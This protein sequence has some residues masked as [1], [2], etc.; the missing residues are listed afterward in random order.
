M[1][2]EKEETVENGEDRPAAEKNCRK[3]SRS[4][5]RCKQSANQQRASLAKILANILAVLRE[6]KPVNGRK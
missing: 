6:T 2:P 5:G 1:T 3:G 4:Q